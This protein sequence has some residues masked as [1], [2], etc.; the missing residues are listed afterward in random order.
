M[1]TASAWKP[2]KLYRIAVKIKCSGRYF[3]SNFQNFLQLWTCWIRLW[4]YEKLW[5]LKFLITRICWFLLFPGKTLHFEALFYFKS[6]GKT[7]SF[8]IMPFV[9]SI[10]TLVNIYIFT[11]VWT[12][13]G[14]WTLQLQICMSF[15]GIAMWCV[16]TRSMKGFHRQQCYRNT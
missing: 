13:H 3:N 9:S 15:T 10:F 6:C 16:H 7:H 4:K 11:G 1:R 8:W 5:I 2:L 14:V 12:L